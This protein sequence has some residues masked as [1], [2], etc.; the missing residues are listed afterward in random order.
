MGGEGLLPYILNCGHLRR[1]KLSALANDV[2]QETGKQPKLLLDFFEIGLEFW[3]PPISVL[4]EV[5]DYPEYTSVCGPD[6]HLV[7]DRARCF[8][9]GLRSLGIEPVFFVDVTLEEDDKLRLS[10]NK[11]TDELL[12]NY[13][14]QQVLE[15]STVQSLPH[16]VCNDLVYR[17]ILYSLRVEGAEMVF[18]AH[19]SSELVMARYSQTHQESCGIVSNDPDFA[20]I[21]GCVLFPLEKFDCENLTGLREG[22]SVDEAPGEII[23]MAI[24]STALAEALEIRQDQLPD[25]AILCGRGTSG[26]FIRRLSVLTALGVEGSGVKDIAAWLNGMSGP[27]MASEVMKELCL[28][29]PEFRV[30]VERSYSAIAL[31]EM[32]PVSTLSP[33]SPAYELVEGEMLGN[34]ELVFAAA[35]RGSVWLSAPCENLNLGKPSIMSKLRPVRKTIYTLLGMSEVCEYGRTKKGVVSVCTSQ[36]D[37]EAS[38]KCLHSLRAL[39]RCGRLVAVY[40][41]TTAL[42]M[43]CVGDIRDVVGDVLKGSLEFPDIEWPKL[44]KLAFLC[45]S[46]RLMVL[47]NRSSSSPLAITD[48]EL[49]ALL[50]SSLTCAT[51]GTILPHI[52]HVLP[53]MRAVSVSEWFCS[54]IDIV[55]EMSCLLGVTEAS[56]EPRNVFYPM[57]FIPYHLALRSHPNLTARQKTDI[58]SVKTAMQTALSF[59]SV[60][61]FCSCIF[62]TDEQPALPTLIA[63]CN[64]ALDEVLK[65]AE[66][67]L[68]R[69]MTA[70]VEE[71]FGV[72]DLEEDHEGPTEEQGAVAASQSET[73]DEKTKPPVVWER[74]DL[75]IMEHC[76]AIVELIA[77]HQVV[78]IEGETGCGKSS[79]VPQ[80]ILK[81]FQN[82]RVLVSQPNYLAAKKLA[83]R[84]RIELLDDAMVT[85]CDELDIDTGNARLVYGTNRF[86][87]QVCCDTRC[88]ICCM[89]MYM[90]LR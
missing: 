83:E 31:E 85:H 10:K 50:L 75:P 70:S 81:H 47:L 55:Y 90:C 40:R 6:F 9:K 69:T 48:R 5:G 74:E 76:E 68:P 51:E 53:S 29:H 67:L 87:M 33:A 42:S 41:L 45:C 66:Q 21:G 49:D 26:G 73:E 79:Q 13:L 57:A 8:V 82:S 80:F 4:Q 58:E 27:L 36:E 88:T 23:S 63:Q 19:Q 7:A 64:T 11:R 39:H 52:V 86:T 20:I 89:Y 37:V 22:V 18:C 2:R 3:S 78:C 56:P 25:L 62:N 43:Q 12:D 1:V 65:N 60:I 32:S 59:P 16:D 30:A 15:R 72:T 71:P 17:Q 46:L 28:Q 38:I 34:C 84:V 35:K 54:A 14:I 24:S 77:G 44:H 61:K